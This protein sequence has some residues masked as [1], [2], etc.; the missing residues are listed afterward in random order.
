MP[1]RIF[2]Y[3]GG[4]YWWES[5]LSDL[6]VIIE[7]LLD[8][9][10]EPKKSFL[11]DGIGYIRTTKGETKYGNRILSESGDVGWEYI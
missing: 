9:L 7:V 1:V 11:I 8:R 6:W 3:T 2:L 5:H 10:I 4:N